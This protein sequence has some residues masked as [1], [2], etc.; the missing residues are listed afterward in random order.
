MP[1]DPSW[2]AYVHTP[3][4][5]LHCP[6]CNFNVSTAPPRWDDWIDGLRSEWAIR[7]SLFPGAANTLYIGGGT[8]SL[9]PPDVLG[10]VLDVVPRAPDAEV[11]IEANPGDL[12]P[13]RLAAWRALGVHRLSLGVQTFDPRFARL[14]ARGHTARQSRELVT[15]VREAG[16]STWN[17][18]VIFALPGQSPADFEADLEAIL[19]TAP[20]HVSLYGLTFEQGTPLTRARDRG[21][22]ADPAEA[23][24]RAMY[25]RAVHALGAAG[26][27]RYEVSNF[28]RPGHRSRHNEATW[29]G[30][31]YV[32]LGPGAHGYAPDGLR[33]VG[34][35]DLDAW[36]ADPRGTEERPHPAGAAIDLVLSTLRHVDGL[37]LQT[38]RSRTGHAPGPATVDAL[39]RAGLVV[40][41]GSALALTHAGFP[42]GDG[43]VA[44]ICDSL[45]PVP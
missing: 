1:A 18:D 29:R 21:S 43:V 2:G 19:E 22:I 26:F 32:G 42:V 24:W 9:A 33:T 10:R 5:R 11:T 4:C 36:R 20:P 3:W 13:A 12:T 39:V 8:P 34:H 16:F 25:D 23:D 31:P 6:Y 45:R 28:A 44:R 41:R 27:E 37:P 14:L 17:V 40:R 15:M 38:L 35:A 7:H 30:G